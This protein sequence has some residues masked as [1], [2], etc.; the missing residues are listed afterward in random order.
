M[1]SSLAGGSIEM[2]RHGHEM[3]IEM[4][5]R[6]EFRREVSGMTADG[7]DLRAKGATELSHAY[8]RALMREV[9]PRADASADHD[10]PRVKSRLTVE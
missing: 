4:A 8:G 6:A 7:I 5:E 1:T 10:R 2:R 9:L 3:R